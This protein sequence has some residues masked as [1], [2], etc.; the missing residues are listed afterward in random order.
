MFCLGYRIRKT[1]NKGHKEALVRGPSTSVGG[2]S[3]IKEKDILDVLE[4]KASS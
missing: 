1:R 4:W 2:E 3:H